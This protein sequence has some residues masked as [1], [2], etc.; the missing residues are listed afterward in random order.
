[1]NPDAGSCTALLTALHEAGQRQA[2]LDVV[3]F[4]ARSGAAP[5]PPVL[6]ALVA[7]CEA[8]GEWPKAVEIVQVPRKL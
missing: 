2:A 8:V 5:E 7:F 6:R 3:D 4:V 1:M